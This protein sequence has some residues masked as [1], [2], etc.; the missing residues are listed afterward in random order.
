M[1]S[2]EGQRRSPEPRTGSRRQL[3][4]R[5]RARA[6]LV[7]VAPQNLDAGRNDFTISL[8]TRKHRQLAQDR[9]QFRRDPPVAFS[10]VMTETE[11]LLAR[12][13]SI[14]VHTASYRLGQH[15]ELLVTD[16]LPQQLRSAK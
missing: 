12:I 2:A 10:E 9:L 4:G 8:Y 14:A 16:A 11:R 3:H 6:A 1:S 5:R 7:E 13:S 15:G